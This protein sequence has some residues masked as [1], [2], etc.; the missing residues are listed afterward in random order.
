MVAELNVNMLEE[1]EQLK[2]DTKG[3]FMEL[4][5]AMDNCIG[6]AN[7]EL[8]GA[9]DA[10]FQSKIKDV[11]DVQNEIKQEL[12]VIR[13]SQE[14]LRST[15]EK[16]N[17]EKKEEKG[18]TYA[19]VASEARIKEPERNNHNNV[20]NVDKRHEK[21][22]SDRRRAPS[23]GLKPD[24][25]R[26]HSRSRKNNPPYNNYRRNGNKPYYSRQFYQ[27]QPDSYRNYERNHG[28]FGLAQPRLYQE[29]QDRQY[30]FPQNQGRWNNLPRYQRFGER[31][32]GHS[33]QFGQNNSMNFDI[34]VYNRFEPLG[35]F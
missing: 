21:I 29:Y 15:N 1:M 17:E 7:K 33:P 23:R 8:R 9:I 5:K 16:S 4:A 19:S 13:N 27:R 3:A 20:P 10:A 12:F 11:F 34:P 35:N 25:E 24:F 6:E 26:N 2:K 31:P 18:V 22:S 32:F 28:R 14:L 30:N